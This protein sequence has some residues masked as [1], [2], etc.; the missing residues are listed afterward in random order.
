MYQPEGQYVLYILYDIIV[1][2]PSTIF[3]VT[4]TVTMSSDITNI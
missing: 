4:I 2:K 3:H 1:L